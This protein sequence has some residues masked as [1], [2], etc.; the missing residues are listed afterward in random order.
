MAQETLIKGARPGQILA[1]LFAGV[2]MGHWI[3]QLLVPFFIRFK[4][5]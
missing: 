1:L 2:F 5:P 3:S 4:K